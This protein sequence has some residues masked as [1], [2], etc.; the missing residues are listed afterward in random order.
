[1]TPRSI[2][3]AG[4]LA[5]C[6]ESCSWLKAAFGCIHLDLH[7][8]DV[9][10]VLEEARRE[11]DL[12]SL[13]ESLMSMMLPFVVGLYELKTSKDLTKRLSGMKSYSVAC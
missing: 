2:L 5:L 11:F 13:T 7:N 10:F 4:V 12:E 3:H 9:V 8:T 6:A 1:M